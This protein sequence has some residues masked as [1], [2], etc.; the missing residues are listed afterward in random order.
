M[1]TIAEETWVVPFM[2]QLTPLRGLEAKIGNFQP[3]EA[4]GPAILQGVVSKR[5]C[6]ADLPPCA[7][8]DTIS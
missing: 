4:R 5:A 1:A 6:S 7:F 8:S 2:S 3:S